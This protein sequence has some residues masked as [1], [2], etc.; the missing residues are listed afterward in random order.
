MFWKAMDRASR[1]NDRSSESDLKRPSCESRTKHKSILWLGAGRESARAEPGNVSLES[2]SAIES[3]SQHAS[4]PR[5][6]PAMVAQC[7]TRCV[8][9]A[10]AAALRKDCERLARSSDSY[11]LARSTY[12]A[13]CA[14]ELFVLDVLEAHAAADWVSRKCGAEWWVQ[15]CDAG[16]GVPLHFDKDEAEMR[17]HGR[18]R[19]PARAT[20]TYLSDH[21][22]TPTLVFD[23]RSDSRSDDDARRSRRRRSRLPVATDSAGQDQGG[24]SH[25][26]VS[27]P[28]LGKHLC[29]KGNRLH[30]VPPEL[31]FSAEGRPRNDTD[32][33]TARPR[34]T[35]MVNCWSKRPA[36]VRRLRAAIA[37][38]LSREKARFE[39]SRPETSAHLLDVV[40]QP[41]IGSPA[42]AAAAAA[43]TAAAV[44]VAPTSRPTNATGASAGADATNSIGDVALISSSRSSVF[45]A[46]PFTARPFAAAAALIE[47]PYCSHTARVT[48]ITL[49]PLD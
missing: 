39:L 6:L 28:V 29:F 47:R 31:D 9:V 16:E 18:F 36:G 38:T 30:G 45:S 11:W 49:V 33:D 41:A 4:S 27:F 46:M 23:S 22:G 48:G 19:H 21:R 40:D 43:A 24:P 35:L 32:A 14:L 20:V 8:P 1:W 15:V 42:A 13:R 10:A 26:F 17:E 25:A 44:A 12:D 5:S 34:V 37:S 7:W 3:S 2:L